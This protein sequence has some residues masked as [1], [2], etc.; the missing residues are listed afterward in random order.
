MVPGRE[1]NVAVVARSCRSYG[2]SEIFKMAGIYKMPV[3]PDLRRDA[4]VATCCHGESGFQRYILVCPVTFAGLARFTKFPLSRAA[5]LMRLF[6]HH[7]GR[8]LNL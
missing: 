3:L 7:S 2:A 4:R 1:I 5:I 8:R 6:H